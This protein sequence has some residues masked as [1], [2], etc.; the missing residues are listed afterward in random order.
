M[1]SSEDD[2]DDNEDGGD[3]KGEPEK[4]G[5][6]PDAGPSQEN[7]PDEDTDIIPCSIDLDVE[8]QPRKLVFRDVAKSMICEVIFHYIIQF[9]L[10][11]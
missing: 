1:S 8:N 4:Q 10:C 5:C 9:F 6:E 11:F 2:D 7:I 3:G